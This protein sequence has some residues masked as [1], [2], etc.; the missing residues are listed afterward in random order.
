MRMIVILAPLVDGAS[1]IATAVGDPGRTRIVQGAIVVL[2]LVGLALAFTAVWLFR[3]TRPDHPVLVP[4][5]LMGQRSWRR[6]DPVFQ[7][8]LLDEARPEG[9]QPLSRMRP[10]P[11]HDEE[12]DRGPS[13]A[14]VSDLVE[15]LSEDET[16]QVHAR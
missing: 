2:V 14:D 15:P 5:E 12:F 1:A 8:R 9:A 7:R 6:A 10:I 3:V 16:T 13:L 11:E 4:L